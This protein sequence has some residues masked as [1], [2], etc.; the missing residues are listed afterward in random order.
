MTLK[1]K[2]ALTVPNI[3]S[4]KIVR[5]PFEGKWY[6]AFKRPQNRGIWFVYGG[7]GS[8]KSTFMMMLA[9]ELA[10]TYKT[11]YNLLEEETDDSDF[12]DRTLMCGMQDV[13]D[14]FTAGRYDLDELDVF[15]SRRDSAHVIIIDSCP[16]LLKKWDE[17]LKF[18][19]K[20]A[21]KKIIILVGHAEGKNPR[22]D[23]QKDIMYDAKMKLFIS[24]YLVSNKGRTIGPNGGEFI[25]WKEGYDKVRGAKKKTS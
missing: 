7:S 13:K 19:R 17:Y 23:L 21:T 15:L 20:W 25:I 18:K 5:I 1:L 9:K 22:T 11:F 6:N 8:G 10:K 4:Q 14:S 2:K 16:Y 3:Q 12:I 24:G